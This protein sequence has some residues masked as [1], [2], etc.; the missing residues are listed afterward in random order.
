MKIS[1]MINNLTAFMEKH[2]DL[3]CWYAVDDEGNDYH[4]VYYDPSFRYVDEEGTVYSDMEDLEYADL[5]ESEVSPI[6]LIN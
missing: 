5:T 1:E 6:C 3:E 4:P 2:G